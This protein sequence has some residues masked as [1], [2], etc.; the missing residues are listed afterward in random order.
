MIIRPFTIIAGL[1]FVL[2][3]AFMFVVK[4]QSQLLDA[5]LTVTNQAASQ[6][7]QNIRVLQAQWAL[8]AD[9]SRLASLATQ[10]TGL[11]PMKPAQLVTLSSLGI[12]LPAPGAKPPG[13][14]PEDPMPV[15]PQLAAAAPAPAA[16]AVAAPV[17]IAAAAPA[18]AS[19]PAAAVHLA[20]AT[21]PAAETVAPRHHAAPERLAT[22]APRHHMSVR[23]ETGSSIYLADASSISAPARLSPGTPMGAQVMAVRAVAS[24]APAPMD[25]GGSMLGMAQGSSQ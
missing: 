5:Q 9:P 15:V 17:Q 6:D 16:L 24:P 18:S 19:P 13:S 7:E 4:H 25:D 12:S 20:A 22:A 23:H 8:E 14:N 11:Q 3:G 1:L 2:S 10:F 21:T